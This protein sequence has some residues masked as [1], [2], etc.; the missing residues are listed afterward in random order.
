M[1]AFFFIVPP[2]RSTQSV[3]AVGAPPVVSRAV[4]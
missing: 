1:K 3:A 2:H 4:F